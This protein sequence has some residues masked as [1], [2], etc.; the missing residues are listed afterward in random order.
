MLHLAAALALATTAVE[1]R[2][3]WS[4]AS[5]TLLGAPS[6]D[7]R[8]LSYV[9]P[10]SG[11]LSVYDV[12][13]GNKRALVT[14][15]AGS[16][17]FAYFSTVS[18]DSRQ[19]AFAWFNDE[20]F[21]DLRV[22]SVEGGSPRVLYRNEEAGFVQPCAWTPDGASILTLFF[23][24]D[25]ISQ[26]ALVPARGGPMKVLRSLHWVY[27]KRMDLAP[28][29]RFIVYDSFAGAASG[30]RTIFLLAADG[31]KEVKLVA[32]PGSHL[33]PLWTPDGKHVVYTSDSGGTM[34]A[35][36]LDIADGKPQGEPR[37]VR[38]NLGRALPLGIT[39]D[40]NYYYGVRSGASD[41]FVTTLDSPAADARRVTLRFPERNSMPAW[42]P[43]G[44]RL[45]YLSRRGTEN[46]GE[47]ARVIVVR[48]ID[49]QE[50][51]EVAVKLAHIERVRWS[52][53]GRLVV[54]GSISKGRSGLYLVDP[55]SSA[56]RPLI[57][58]AGGPYRGF[59]GVMPAGGRRI[60]YLR[61]EGELRAR[62]LESGEE[63][64]LARGASLSHLAL[65][66]D[67]KTLACV[68]GPD[69][70]LLTPVE[71][72]ER[73]RLPFAEATEL[74]WGK[75]LIA[76]KGSELWRLDPEGGPPRLLP[77][78]GNRERGFSQHPDGKRIALTAGKEKSEIRV[79]RLR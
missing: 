30:D 51:R 38:R 73:K 63:M 75:V 66:P 2:V 8:F 52:G 48:E 37:V 21:Y 6:P 58:E 3:V 36:M 35:W 68:A 23:R 39:R 76:G 33:F 44:R 46:F 7:G 71:G 24:K 62:D 14:R 26:I 67:G 55:Q 61:G 13:G 10:G 5:V 19:I 4:D 40:W 70:I 18:P 56:M 60:Y 43:D 57:E 34:D 32:R 50:E 53:D 45:A 31:S 69:S 12:A 77:S 49:R 41:V 22:V 17:E 11:A 16:N 79:L 78:P 15:P 42:S 64:T 47:Q 59:E 29:G 1:P 74:D 20:G 27:P 9:E 25:N 65:S 72:G 28:D 54:S